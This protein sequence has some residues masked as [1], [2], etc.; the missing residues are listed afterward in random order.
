V[1]LIKFIL[2]LFLFF[3][4][5]FCCLFCTFL[6]K[7]SRLRL[8]SKITS[9]FSSLLLKVF[10]VH[11]KIKGNLG[12]KKLKLVIS[13]HVSYLDILII[14]K[15]VPSIFV[16]S[17]DVENEFFTGFLSKIGGSIFVNRRT[18]SKKLYREILE[19]T[20]VI[21]HSCPVCLFPEATSSDGK[22][23]LPFKSTFFEVAKKVSIC[24]QP[25]CLKYSDSRVCYYGD[26]KFFSH[27]WKLLKIKRIDVQIFILE[28]VS[29]IENTRHEMCNIAHSRILKAFNGEETCKD[30]QKF[31]TDNWN[32]KIS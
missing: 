2:F 3:S 9:F 31:I 20:K 18:L 32:L 6:Q 15:L 29:N 12:S 7:T 13:N 8:I 10:G 28:H 1:R 11:I 26:M 4:Y 25:V 23:V 5:V 21:V 16:T 22:T 14:A 30:S 17:T 19:I 24:V 27:F